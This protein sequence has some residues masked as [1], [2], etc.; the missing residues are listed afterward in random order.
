MRIRLYIAV[1]LD[2]FI[3]AADGGVDW[4]EPFFDADY[5]YDAF[6]QGIRCAVMGR[7]TYEQ[8][9]D[10]GEWPYPDH[11]V[12]V[13]SR[14]P[15]GAVPPRTHVWAEDPASLVRHLRAQADEG[16]CWLIGGGQIL[17]AF[18][19]LGAV[20]EYEIFVMPVVLGSGI[21]LFPD[22]FPAGR[23]QLQDV[24]AWENGAVRLLYVRAGPEEPEV[25]DEG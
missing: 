14:S 7:L 4:L 13:L 5:G 9:L 10:F 19:R 20:D 15:L 3:A 8:V 16:D 6:M 11:D 25:L 22:P 24:T 21:P 18:E 23:L 2:G 1:S 12:W 17:R